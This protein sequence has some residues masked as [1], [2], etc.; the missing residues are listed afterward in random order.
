MCG[1]RK[2]VAKSPLLLVLNS[3]SRECQDSNEKD[4]KRSAQ[5]SVPLIHLHRDQDC[6]ETDADP[7]VSPQQ[8]EK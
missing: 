1:C 7:S 4:E 3:H 5:S 8:C 2:V 6:G